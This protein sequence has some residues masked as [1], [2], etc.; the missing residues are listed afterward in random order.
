MK[1]CTVSEGDDQGHVLI[2]A[3]GELNDFLPPALRCT[4]FSYPMA[5]GNHLKHL[6]ESAGIP[7]TE[8]E[9]LLLNGR[10]VGFD[11]LVSSGDRVSVFP[12]FETLDVGPVVRLRPKPLRKTRFVLD[13]H[14]GKLAVI[15]RLM[16]FDACFP[17]DVDDLVL[18]EISA[19]EHRILLTR[20]RMLLKRSMVTHGCYVRSSNPEEQAC[21]ILDRLD[22]RSSAKPFTRCPGCSG[23]LLEVEKERI[24]H[25]LEPL[26]RMYCHEF[27]IC[28]GC[29]GIYWKGSH[30]QALMSLMKRL[31]C[32]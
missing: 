10:S 19:S 17:G 14:L 7:H 21:E 28:G 20:D 24:L 3:Y 5:G 30:Y 12:V 1:S 8:I 11:A 4:E 25:R 22:L 2:R 13:V 27:R 15:L 26:T 32:G 31:G 18:A 6:V 23:K 29:G 16:G 9:L